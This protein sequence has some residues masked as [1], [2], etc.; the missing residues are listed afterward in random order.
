MIKCYQIVGRV[1]YET[2]DFAIRCTT[3]FYVFNIS[4]T[5]LQFPALS[6]VTFNVS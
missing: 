6:A 2:A 1:D 3:L 4:N 5:N